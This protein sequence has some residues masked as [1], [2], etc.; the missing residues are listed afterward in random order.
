[1]YVRMH[2]RART[3]HALAFQ[4]DTM[5]PLTP[6]SAPSSAWYLAIGKVHTG[7][8]EEEGAARRPGGS[9]SAGGGSS[10]AP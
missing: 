1:M 10:R 2:A 3:Q 4:S 6:L 8:A 7:A 9:G 5:S